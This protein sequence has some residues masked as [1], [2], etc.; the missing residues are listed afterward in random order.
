MRLKLPSL[1]LCD[2]IE[3][4]DRSVVSIASVILQDIS[5]IKIDD[6]QQVVDRMKI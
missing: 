2:R 4:S 1:E 3:K 6:K 5:I